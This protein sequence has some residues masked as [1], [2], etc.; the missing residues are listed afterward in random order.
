MLQKVCYGCMVQ[1]DRVKK[2]KVT[3]GG[4]LL[5]TWKLKEGQRWRMDA[6]G[7]Q[8]RGGGH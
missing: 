8:G 5:V 2:R 4:L 1:V 6:E 7:D 3:M